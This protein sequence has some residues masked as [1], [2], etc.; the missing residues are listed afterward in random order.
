MIDP[1]FFSRLF[2]IVRMVFRILFVIV[3]WLPEMILAGDV[4]DLWNRE[5]IPPGNKEADNSHH[6]INS[7]RKSTSSGYLVFFVCFKHLGNA[8]IKRFC[9]GLERVS[10]SNPG[11]WVFAPQ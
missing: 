5:I 3:F 6:F 1:L 4:V 2:G 8:K 10:G 11:V 7:H 9:L